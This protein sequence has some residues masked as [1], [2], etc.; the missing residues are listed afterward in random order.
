[1]NTVPDANP[2]NKTRIYVRLSR[3]A[4]AGLDDL[5]TNIGALYRDDVNLL[6]SH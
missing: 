6:A 2:N 1:M 3:H 4:E 5:S